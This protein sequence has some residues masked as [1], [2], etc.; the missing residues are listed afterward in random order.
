MPQEQQ[1]QQRAAAIGVDNIIAA[2]ETLNDGYPYFAV[3]YNKTNKWFQYNKDDY[4]KAK[5]FLENN[6]GLVEETGDNY[7]YYLNIYSESK[8]NYPNSGMIASLPFRMNPFNESGAIAGFNGSADSFTKMLADA[9]A[10]HLE[11]VKEIAELKLANQ[12]LDWFD[13]ISGIMET[14]GAAGVI[15]PIVQPFLGA[16]MGIFTK[17]AGVQPAAYEQVQARPV[18][19]GPMPSQ[20]DLNTQL[21]AA[22]DRLEQHGNLLEIITVL[23]NFADKNPAAFKSYFDILKTQA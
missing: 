18:I 3:Y 20:D 17:L 9:H 11:L 23:A 12:P 6:L 10:K 14:P 2:W 1:R 5:V 22:L 13:R 15:V 7:L 16:I 21:D 4:D 19:A 8:P